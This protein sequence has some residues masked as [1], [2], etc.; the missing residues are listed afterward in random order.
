MDF[1]LVAPRDLQVSRNE[2]AGPRSSVDTLRGLVRQNSNAIGGHF[3][4]EQYRIA[5]H[6]RRAVQRDAGSNGSYLFFRDG[7]R[8]ARITGT[9][10][11]V[12][13]VEQIFERHRYHGPKQGGPQL[14][15]SSS[16]PATR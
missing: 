9:G 10:R 15:A 1:F 13:A 12:E 2:R 5:R 14:A 4:S 3:N 16:G 8:A 6:I 11:R 7:K